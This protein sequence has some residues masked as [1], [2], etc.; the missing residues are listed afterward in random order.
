MNR[1]SRTATEHR[2][3]VLESVATSPKEATRDTIVKDAA[4][5]GWTDRKQIVTMI[6]QLRREGLI[7]L[8]EG[9]R[10]AFFLTTGGLEA[11]QHGAFDRKLPEFAERPKA[12]RKK[13][14]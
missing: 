8:K 5:I 12:R 3:I 4:S 14:K 11:L 6:H 7:G 10:N 9:E 13:E 1:G 2:A